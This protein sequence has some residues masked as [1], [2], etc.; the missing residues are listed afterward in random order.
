MY[1]CLVS[2][3]YNN[4]RRVMISTYLFL[5]SSSQTYIKDN[6]FQ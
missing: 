5:F 2:L 3:S 1:E 4:E 6:C